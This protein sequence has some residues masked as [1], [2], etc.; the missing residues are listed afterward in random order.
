MLTTSI[1]GDLSPQKP[2]R[3]PDGTF[4]PRSILGDP[5]SYEAMD[6]K[7]HADGSWRDDLSNPPILRSTI[8]A[9][10]RNMMNLLD[11]IHFAEEKKDKDQVFADPTFDSES[12][13]AILKSRQKK[14]TQ[15]MRMERERSASLQ[16]SLSTLE[17]FDQKRDRKVLALWQE[18]QRVWERVQRGIRAQLKNREQPL[19]MESTDEYRAR[20]EE[21]DTLQLAKLPHERFG[22]NAW[23]MDLRQGG[24]KHV[25][26]GHA[27]SG[28]ESRIKFEL[29]EP[30]VVR[31]PG[32]GR[33]M[34]TDFLTTKFSP[35]LAETR[36]QIQET[37]R[38]V[39]PHGISLAEA[40]HLVVFSKDLF[41]W[42]IDSST[43]FFSEEASVVSRQDEELEA[44]SARSDHAE[45]D[46][47]LS[48]RFHSLCDIVLSCLEG[49]SA[50]YMASFTN[51]GSTAVAYSWRKLIAGRSKDTE[52]SFGPVQQ[53]FRERDRDEKP[54][55]HLLSK[56]RQSIFCLNHK[57]FALPGE[58]IRTEFVF[59]S[60]E[61]I[62]VIA[63]RW[64]LETTPPSKIHLDDR[65]AMVPVPMQGL[66]IVIRGHSSTYDASVTLR[67]TIINSL[68]YRTVQSFFEEV[69]YSCVRRVRVPLRVPELNRRKLDLFQTTNAKL[70]LDLQPTYITLDR[71]ASFFEAYDEV[72]QFIG[73]VEGSREA[74]RKEVDPHVVYATESILDEVGMRQRT[75]SNRSILFPENTLVSSECSAGF[76]FM[77]HE[78][79][80]F[81]EV[82]EEM[83]SLP[84]DM[85]VD[86]MLSHLHATTEIIQDIINMESILEEVR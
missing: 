73:E 34:K 16:N 30:L 72:A 44:L 10:K 71:V 75:L 29:K 12:Y 36:S 7:H 68:E 22:Q 43:H 45:L 15:A 13:M 50:T 17:R 33:A 64:M 39:R 62:G 55:S 18:R 47:K 42:A 35:A 86:R 82:S 57:G 28:L 38:R 60:K 32:Q 11:I 80:F 3:N 5:A 67:S 85:D 41:E 23:E 61:R 70:F 31:K 76:V 48:I 20:L 51:I 83:I 9:K 19:L 27:F 8:K 53:M 52:E 66:Q 54:R 74:L 79:E 14:A 6:L 4:V 84:W 81:D 37:L 21:F 69:V 58:T 49:S 77:I 40:D 56:E 1:V 59:Q 24:M 78:Q 65:T 63:E 2:L 26:K 46:E 25:T